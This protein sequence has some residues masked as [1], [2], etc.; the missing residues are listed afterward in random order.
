[1]TGGYG[2]EKTLIWM[3]WVNGEVSKVYIET[4][5]FQFA[6]GNSKWIGQGQGQ[7]PEELEPLN[8]GWG[9]CTKEK[10]KEEREGQEENQEAVV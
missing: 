3:W 10:E 9:K 6:F 1:M 7:N 8:V 4:W 2:E 5:L